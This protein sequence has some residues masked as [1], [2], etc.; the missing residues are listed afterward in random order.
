MKAQ[1]Y[2]MGDLAEYTGKSEITYG[3]IFYEVILLTG[4]KKGEMRSVVYPPD[5]L[6]TIRQDDNE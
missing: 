1:L 4:H 3:Q 6:M 5:S 2:F